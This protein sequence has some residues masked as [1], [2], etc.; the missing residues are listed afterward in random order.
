MLPAHEGGAGSV[1]QNIL[2]LIRMIHSLWHAAPVA[3]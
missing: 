1:D 2:T 3:E